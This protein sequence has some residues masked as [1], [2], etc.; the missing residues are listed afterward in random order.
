MIAERKHRSCDGAAV[1][2]RREV[3]RARVKAAVVKYRF[4][5]GCA[6]TAACAKA[7]FERLKFVTEVM[8]AATIDRQVREISGRSPQQQNSPAPRAGPHRKRFLKAASRE[9]EEW[10]L[11]AD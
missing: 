7:Q 4:K 6:G 11:S 8:D 2:R 1:K 10:L 3:L 9:E 5:D